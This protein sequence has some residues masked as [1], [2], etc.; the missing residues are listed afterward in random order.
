MGSHGTSINAALF[1]STVSFPWPALPAKNNDS[2]PVVSH[3]KTKEADSLQAQPRAALKNN[4]S[5]QPKG[6]MYPGSS[7]SRSHS[8]RALGPGWLLMKVGHTYVSS[9]ICISPHSYVW[10][11]MYW[12]MLGLYLTEKWGPVTETQNFS[13]PRAT[14]ANWSPCRPPV[15][16]KRREEKFGPSC[17]QM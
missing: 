16:H 10:G 13:D 8:P 9:P 7:H 15:P 6:H 12:R 5:T 3:V 14:M 2:Q 17:F 1:P 11:Y 4:A